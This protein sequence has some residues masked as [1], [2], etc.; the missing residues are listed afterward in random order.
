MRVFFWPKFLGPPN[1]RES[2]S[3]F[4]GLIKKIFKKVFWGNR[5]LFCV[6]TFVKKKRCLEEIVKCSVHTCSDLKPFRK[7]YSYLF[8]TSH[9]CLLFFCV[10][11]CV[12][13]SLKYLSLL[14]CYNSLVPLFSRPLKNIHPEEFLV[15]FT[16]DEQKI[17]AMLNI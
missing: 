4:F 2:C 6:N 16:V 11:N 10:W 13:P 5:W 15:L 9:W 3:N 8:L 17:T 7:H 14:D 12:V 1:W